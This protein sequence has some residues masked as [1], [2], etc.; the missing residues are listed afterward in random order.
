VLRNRHLGGKHFADDEEVEAEVWKWLRQQSEDFYA[1]GFDALVKQ[2][3]KCINDC[4]GYVKI[5]MFFSIF[6]Y[7]MLYVLDPFVTYLL[8]PPC[9]IM[10]S[11]LKC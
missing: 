6:E 7:Y 4:G 2:W 9:N 5:Q 10:P 3:D 11:L 8:T 1:A